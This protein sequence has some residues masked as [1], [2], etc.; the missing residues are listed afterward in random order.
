MAKRTHVHGK[1]WRQFVV[2][3]G[4][5]CIKKDK[6][7]IPCGSTEYLEFH[8]PFG[9]DHLGWGTMQ[10]RVL[11]CFTHHMEEHPE[12]KA[13]TRKT[14]NNLNAD[15]SR[16]ITECGGYD[17]WIEKFGLIDRFGILLQ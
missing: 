1:Q 8:E 17:K 14:G 7:G 2:D 10:S 16:E 9:E 6:N 15:V 11:L 12:I 3:C 5:M 4:G 13:L